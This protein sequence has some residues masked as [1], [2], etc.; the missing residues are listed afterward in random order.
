[1]TSHSL[2][3]IMILDRGGAPRFYMQLDPRAFDMD[4]FLGSSFFAAIDM[5]STQIIEQSEPFFQVDYGARVFTIIHGVETNLVAVCKRRLSDETLEIL[6][7]LLAEFELDWIPAAEAFELDDSFIEVYLESFGERVLNKIS[8]QEIPDS[9]V[10]YFTDR[11]DDL[12]PDFSPVIKFINGSRSVKEIRELSGVTQSEMLVD[13]SKLWAQRV[14][15]FRNMLSFK[16]FLSARTKFLRYTQATSTEVRGLLDL[17]PEM[18]GIIPRLAGLIDGRRTV[19]ELLDELG[20][21]YDEREVLRV[22]DY[23]RENEVIEVLSHEKR[24]ILLAKEL[25]SFSLR[26]AEEIWGIRD[27]TTI[28]RTIVNRVQA[29]EIIGQLTLKDGQW[30]VDFDFK[31][32]EG[33]ETNRLSLMYGEWMKILAQFSAA[34]DRKQLN[35]FIISL[36]QKF[37]NRI[38]DRYAIFDLRGLEEFSFWL[39]QLETES[40]P[41][42]E[43]D[44][45]YPLEKIDNTVLEDLVHI[46]IERGQTIYGSEM[47]VGISGSA[48]IPLVDGMPVT[49]SMG[50]RSDSFKYFMNEYSKISSAAKLTVLILS[51]QRGIP[52]P[53]EITM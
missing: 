32:L 8:F 37:F 30:F 51:R 52:I 33:L 46:L 35:A 19:R 9:W 45:T 4:P 7:S 23:L 10:P 5:F 53:S 2:E 25:V 11:P 14:I 16:D 13:M 38:I 15:R 47:I 26:S 34:L 39:E 6:D 20:S 41:R 48:G 29:P 12:L 44:R 27:I 31:P 1:M 22:L 42:A 18:V 43:I 24:R 21:Y 49:R 40:W 36:T 17:H 3:A 28:V 50:S